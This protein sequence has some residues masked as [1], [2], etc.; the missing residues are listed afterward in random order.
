MKK[1]YSILAVCSL[2]IAFTSCKDD[3]STV[4]DG[5][6]LFVMEDILEESAKAETTN[7]PVSF[8]LMNPADKNQQIT[9]KVDHNSNPAFITVGSEI[10]VSFNEGENITSI[11][12]PLNQTNFQPCSSDT[13]K[14]SV[15][16]S[17]Y[18]TLNNECT[19]VVK[20]SSTMDD[21]KVLE[22]VG[23]YLDPNSGVVYNVTHVSDSTFLIDHFFGVPAPLSPQPIKFT[24]SYSDENSYTTHIESGLLYTN[25]TLGP[26]WIE[27]SIYDGRTLRGEFDYCQKT[28][29]LFGARKVFNDGSWFDPYVS[30]YV[31]YGFQFVKL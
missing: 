30:G 1:I 7:I 8:G 24:L 21:S 14:L 10:T 17:P 28:F 27:G 22:W 25:P 16:D 3:K 19:I 20:T 15:K 9:L 29:T 26:I 11:N 23:A 4:Y 31:Y 6:Q 5:P 18:S 2:L 12:I 13:I